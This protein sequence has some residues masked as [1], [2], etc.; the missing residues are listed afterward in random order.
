MHATRFDEFDDGNDATEADWRAYFDDHAYDVDG[1]WYYARL[2]K[3]ERELLGDTTALAT[4]TFGLAEGG[5]SHPT[6]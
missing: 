1:D 4:T 2:K 3:G 6:L 5:R